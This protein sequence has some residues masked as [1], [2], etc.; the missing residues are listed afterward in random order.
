MDSLRSNSRRGKSSSPS[1]SSSLSSSPVRSMT[2]FGKMGLGTTMV[3]AERWGEVECE[4]AGAKKTKMEAMKKKARAFLS[5]VSLLRRPH[6]HTFQ[7]MVSAV[8]H[9]N[10]A[11]IAMVISL[12]LSDGA[13]VSHVLPSAFVNDAVIAVVVTLQ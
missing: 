13:V 8:Q 3:K 4:A 5:S 7:G 6:D 9:R 2:V 11:L 1:S 12:E 10:G